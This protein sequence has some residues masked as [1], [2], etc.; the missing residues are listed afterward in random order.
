LDATGQALRDALAA[1]NRAGTALTD[2]IKATTP[3]Q[4]ILAMS[5]AWDLKRSKRDWQLPED[6]MMLVEVCKVHPAAVP[7]AE[8]FLRTARISRIAPA[9]AP[10]LL[11]AA[12]AA[13]VIKDW[14]ASS[15]LSALTKNAFTQAKN[16]KAGP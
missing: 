13:P 4:A 10:Q 9:L 14:L 6:V 2:S 8:S 11:G 15:E 12:W 7:K 16:P 1:A 5:R 3:E